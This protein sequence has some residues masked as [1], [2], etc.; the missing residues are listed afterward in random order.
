M[1]TQEFVS[2]SHRHELAWRGAPSILLYL[3]TCSW[4]LFDKRALGIWCNGIVPYKANEFLMHKAIQLA[5]T[6]TVR[7]K[8]TRQHH[9]HFSYTYHVIVAILTYLFT[10]AA[11]DL[12]TFSHLAGHASGGQPQKAYNTIAAI[13]AL[14]YFCSEKIYYM[15]LLEALICAYFS[16]YRQ[17]H[18]SFSMVSY[19]FDFHAILRL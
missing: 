15:L 2:F 17:E 9:K 10:Y 3:Q 5:H 16:C 1:K 4:F 12:P 13:F 19:R 6:I 18:H 14:H 11:R 8:L 7:S